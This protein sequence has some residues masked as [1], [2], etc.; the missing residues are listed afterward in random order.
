MK[1]SCQNSAYRHL[2]MLTY[3]KLGNISLYCKIVFAFAMIES[4]FTR[5]FHF[6][7]SFSFRCFLPRAIHLSS[8][9]T[10]YTCFF[11]LFPIEYKIESE[12]KDYHF[13]C[14]L[15]SGQVKPIL[16]F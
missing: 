7:T 8:L 1:I 15:L 10:L 14:F 2:E 13:Y 4:D 5:I 9:T 6:S 16:D 12:R 3:M 11:F